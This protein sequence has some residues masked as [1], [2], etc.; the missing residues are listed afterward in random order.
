LTAVQLSA[1]TNNVWPKFKYRRYQKI[2]G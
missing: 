1:V 2:N